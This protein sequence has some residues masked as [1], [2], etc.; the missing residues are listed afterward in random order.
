MNLILMATVLVALSSL[1]L[2]LTG[3]VLA[4]QPEIWKSWGRSIAIAL[5]VAIAVSAIGCAQ[6]LF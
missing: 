2:G 3:L 4:R 6:L 1:Y 5:Q